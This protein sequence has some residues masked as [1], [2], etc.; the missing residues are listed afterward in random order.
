VSLTFLA[1]PEEIMTTENQ[2]DDDLSNES[3]N[4]SGSNNKAPDVEALV[5]ARVDAALKKM[6]D[7]L[8]KAYAARD[9]AESKAKELE[10]KQRK[11]EIERLESEGK[12]AE[13]LQKKL[14]DVVVENTTLKKQVVEL[15]RDVNLSEQMNGLTFRNERAAKLAYKEIVGELVQD[16]NGEWKHKSGLSIKDFV[17]KFSEDEDQAFLFK[18]K[19]SS[20]TGLSR[21]V[22]DDGGNRTK[23]KKTSLFDMSQEDVLKLAAEGKL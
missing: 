2:T 17:K 12:L 15:T 22:E 13:A 20:G 1:V 5:A 7:N 18:P 16:A 6:K 11:L 8:D 3:N 10:D 14:D 19:Q 23:G 9:S 4:V 21:T